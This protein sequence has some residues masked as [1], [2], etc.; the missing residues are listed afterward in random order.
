MK[1]KEIT[2]IVLTGGPCAGKTSALARIQN[3]FSKL[4]YFV[5][6]VPEAATEAILS[7][8][9]PRTLIN[10]VYF[11]KIHMQLQLKH[12]KIF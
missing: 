8:A 6:F 11:Q 7:G 1:E 10:N 5:I 12:E 9:S 3:E 2:R 4:G